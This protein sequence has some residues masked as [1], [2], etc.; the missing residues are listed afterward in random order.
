MSISY[1]EATRTFNLVAGHTSYAMRVVREGYLAHLYWGPRLHRLGEGRQIVYKDRGFCPNPTP[2]D[3]AFSLDTLP[4]EY[5]QY[6]NGDFRSP[7]YGIRDEAGAHVSDLRYVGHRISPGKP[8]L[9]GLPATFAG[10]GE[11]DT[12][13][14]R[15]EDAASGLVVLLAYTAFRD[16]DVICRSVRLENHGAAPLTL[17]KALSMSVDLRDDDTTSLGDWVPDPRKLPHG[18]GWLSD[19]VHELGLGFGIWLEPEMVSADSDLFRAHPDWALHTEGRPYTW[20]RGQLVLDL[21]R[22]EVRDFIVSAVE[23]VLRSARIEYVKWDMNRHLTDVATSWLPAGRQGEVFHRYVLGLYEVLDRL[24]REFPDV[25]WESC[26]SGGGRFDPGMLYYMPQTWT[27]DDTDPVCRAGI[28]AA[29]S[30]TYPQ[31]SMG[32]HVSVSPNQQTGRRSSLATRANVATC[33]SFGLELDLTACT[34]EELAEIAEAVRVHKELRRTL[35]FGKLWR[36]RASFAATRPAGTWSARTG[37]TSWRARRPGS[38]C[39]PCHVPGAALQRHHRRA[40]AGRLPPPRGQ[41]A[42]QEGEHRAHRG[43]GHGDPSA[44]P[45]RRAVGGARRARR[46]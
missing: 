43:H 44:A 34:E 33:G 7:A 32:A 11:A 20:G 26:S 13:E 37:R 28:Q 41:V 38:A 39:W 17:T 25:L 18:L 6:G 46:R 36:A 10:E 45:R 31:V 12:L 22:P 35:Q 23:G 19:R 14:V 3:R 16:L 30:L 8:A 9:E 40:P 5:P 29:T 15:M 27:S 21:T 1:D 42:H 24:T 4:Q 2:D